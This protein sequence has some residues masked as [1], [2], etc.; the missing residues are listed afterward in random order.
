MDVQKIFVKWI[1]NCI[2]K[3]MMHEWMEGIMF[4]PIKLCLEDSS[5]GFSMFICL[6]FVSRHSH[7]LIPIIICHF[8]EN[9]RKEKKIP[10]TFIIQTLKVP[11]Y[12][13]RVCVFIIVPKD[14]PA[15]ILY[16][17]NFHLAVSLNKIISYSYYFNDN[18]IEHDSCAILCFT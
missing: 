5:T 6:Y 8:I 1:N 9:R 2:N 10:Y 17:N 7:S 13:F 12:H 16:E 4:F 11:L 3:W 14:I 18:L 15:A